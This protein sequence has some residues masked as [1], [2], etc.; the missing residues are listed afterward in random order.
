[1]C[2]QTNCLSLL[3]ILVGI[4]DIS[5]SKRY[6]ICNGM[7]R[8]NISHAKGLHYNNHMSTKY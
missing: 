3:K 4:R 7:L 2:F 5:Y 1:M 8:I 6:V